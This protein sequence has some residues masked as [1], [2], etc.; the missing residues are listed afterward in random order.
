[1]LNAPFSYLVKKGN[2]I[3]SFGAV[4]FSGVIFATT[5]LV[6]TYL[7]GVLPDLT[8]VRTWYFGSAILGIVAWGILSFL[9]YFIALLVLHSSKPSLGITAFLRVSGYALIPFAFWNVP[10]VG[11]LIPIIG[12]YLWIMASKHGFETNLEGAVIISLPIIVVYL[13]VAMLPSLP[14]LPFGGGLD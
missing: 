3:W 4:V 6:Q 12:V 7:R 13:F 1:L 8:L 14:L 11:W 2:M 10:W 5:L 9:S